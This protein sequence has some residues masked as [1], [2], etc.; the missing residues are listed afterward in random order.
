M[1]KKEKELVDALVN[2]L[3]VSNASGQWI[4]GLWCISEDD[5]DAIDEALEEVVKVLGCA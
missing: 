4:S 2:A 5:S 3:L 1:T